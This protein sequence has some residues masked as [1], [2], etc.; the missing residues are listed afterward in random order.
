MWQEKSQSKV[1]K[2]KPGQR[3]RGISGNETK[4]YVRRVAKSP[5]GKKWIAVIT[6]IT[7]KEINRLVATPYGGTNGIYFASVSDAIVSD[8]V[9]RLK[10]RY[11]WNESMDK[12]SF[13]KS[14]NSGTRLKNGLLKKSSKSSP[15]M[16]VKLPKNFGKLKNFENYRSGK[17]KVGNKWYSKEQLGSY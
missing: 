9:K 14:T 10:P 13:K 6:G 12:V 3:R 8:L 7:R 17:I 16:K 2:Q 5:T 1:S 4:G 15:I 11:S